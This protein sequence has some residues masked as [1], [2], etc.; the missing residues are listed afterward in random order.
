MAL[1]R[2]PAGANSTAKDL[3]SASSPPLDAVYAA[4]PGRALGP[5]I[6]VILM[7]E[8]FFYSVLHAKKYSLPEHMLN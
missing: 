1:H 5:A 4:S 7:I 8:P 3:V 6:D 2:K